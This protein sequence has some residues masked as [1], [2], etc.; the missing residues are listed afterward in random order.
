MKNNTEH[1]STSKPFPTK[2]QIIKNI[3]SS[4]SKT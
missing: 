4:P 1:G 3:T 2:T